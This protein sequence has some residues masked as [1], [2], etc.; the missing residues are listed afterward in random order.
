M[1]L[2]LFTQDPQ[3]STWSRTPAIPGLRPLTRDAARYRSYFPSVDV[4][5][6]T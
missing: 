4:I 1:L 6:P 5:A 3:W 2:D